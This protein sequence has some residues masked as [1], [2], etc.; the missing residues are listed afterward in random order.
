MFFFPKTLW[1]LPQP[2]STSPYKFFGSEEYGK[3]GIGA[4]P[5]HASW[6]A[7]LYMIGENRQLITN[8]PVELEK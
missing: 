7:G 5:L 1:E 8:E 3:S 6:G 4:D 2:V